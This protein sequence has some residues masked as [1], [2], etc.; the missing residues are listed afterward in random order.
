MVRHTGGIRRH[1]WMLPARLSLFSSLIIHGRTEAVL[2]EQ[3]GVTWPV[4]QIQRCALFL[5]DKFARNCF[6]FTLVFTSPHVG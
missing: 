6:H 3:L 4:L 5:R 1:C 2:P